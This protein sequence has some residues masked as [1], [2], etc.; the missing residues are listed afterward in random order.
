[1]STPSP[2]PEKQLDLFQAAGIDWESLESLTPAQQETLGKHS[3]VWIER[4]NPKLYKSLELHIMM[5]VSDKLI[6]T[7]CDVSTNVV[8]AIRGKAA[9]QLSME[10]HKRVLLSGIA[11][12][13]V[14]LLA[15]IN[16]LIESDA[17]MEPK[18]MT[19]LFDV[20]TTKGLLLNGE[21]TARVDNGSQRQ[22]TEAEAAFLAMLPQLQRQARQGMDLPARNVID[23][24]EAAQAEPIAADAFTGPLPKHNECL[25]EPTEAFI[26]EAPRPLHTYEHTN[27]PT[28][29]PDFEEGRGG[30]GDPRPDPLS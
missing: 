30:S 23:I 10:D 18:D 2:D 11:R 27:N 20:L 5:G 3:A 21:A 12:G 16:Q 15:R 14:G 17:K 29:T 4:F 28:E 19:K 26:Y 22:P 25:A 24:T 13:S 1:M 6:G 8:A 7:M 9:S